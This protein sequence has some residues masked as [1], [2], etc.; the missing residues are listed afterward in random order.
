VTVLCDD[1]ACPSAISCAL[2]FGR[3]QAYAEMRERTPPIKKREREIGKDACGEYRT[4]RPKAWL[5]PYGRSV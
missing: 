3:S 4:D 2:H 5:M 1:W